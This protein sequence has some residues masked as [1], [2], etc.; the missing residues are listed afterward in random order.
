MHGVYNLKVLYLMMLKD[1]VLAMRMI[2]R[3][4]KR[5]TLP[6]QSYKQIYRG[7]L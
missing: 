5:Q 4:Q 2:I 7:Y 1:G 6:R 3:E